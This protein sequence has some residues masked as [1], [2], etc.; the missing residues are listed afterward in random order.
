M[1][2]N[3]RRA[4]CPVCHST[5]KVLFPASATH[6]R[7]AQDKRHGFLLF[8]AEK[9][10]ASKARLSQASSRAYPSPPSLS[11]SEAEKAATAKIAGQQ[12]VSEK[13][14]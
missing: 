13:K 5:F 7:A 10:K 9:S 8:Q 4:L 1:P 11:A 14:C 3:T 2:H 12:L 6:V